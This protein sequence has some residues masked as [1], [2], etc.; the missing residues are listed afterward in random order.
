MY[1]LNRLFRL[2]ALLAVILAL[3]A[4]TASAA[5][6]RCRVDPIFVLSNGDVVNVTVDIGTDPAKV[7]NIHYVL[8]VPAGVT[9]KEIVH[10]A[11]G[12]R[13]HETTKVYQDSSAGTYLSDTVV[14]TRGPGG[15]VPVIAYARLN[16][17][18]VQSIFG[19]NGQNLILTVSR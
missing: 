19:Y 6:V 11:R 9:V 16:G 7:K 12:F 2:L 4:T 8:H 14:S 5:L 10:T 17:V 3:P 13:I 1:K 18:P 15:T